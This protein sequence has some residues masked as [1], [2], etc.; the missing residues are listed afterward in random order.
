METIHLNLQRLRK[1]NGF[2]Q[3]QM[4]DFL[5]IQ[6]SAYSNYE[7]GDRQIPLD[8]MEKAANLFGCELNYF[9]E[10]NPREVEDALLCAFRSDGLSAEDMKVVADFKKIV[11][12]YIM[13][14]RQLD[15]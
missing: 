3:Q 10:E 6:R 15:A 4:A 9:F 8:I 13:I 14:S 5:G 11:R 12:N 1:A 7:L 2:T